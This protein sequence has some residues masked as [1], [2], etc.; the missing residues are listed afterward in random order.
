MILHRSF[1]LSAAA[2]LSER[3]QAINW[4][5]TEVD[6][7]RRK[8]ACRRFEL[9]SELIRAQAVVRKELGPGQWEAWCRGNIHRSQGDIQKVMKL[10]LARD[11]MAAHEAE[12]AASRN[13]RAER[14]EKVR[15]ADHAAS[16]RHVPA[17]E[18]RPVLTVV[19]ETVS[20]AAPEAAVDPVQAGVATLNAALASI[21]APIRAQVLAGFF[22]EHRHAA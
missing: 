18:H 4:L 3:A 2:T 5:F 20:E 7:A 15:V 19:S 1:R 9:G 14:T 17:S 10:A 13:Q 8:T 21:P 22:K 6:A 16:M 12:K 11:P